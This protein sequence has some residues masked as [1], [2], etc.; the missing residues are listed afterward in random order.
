MPRR[1]RKSPVPYF[2]WLV[3]FRTAQHAIAKAYDETVGKNPP[4]PAFGAVFRIVVNKVILPKFRDLLAKKKGVESMEEIYDMLVDTLDWAVKTPEVR[5]A[6]RVAVAEL[7]VGKVEGLSVDEVAR[8]VYEALPTILEYLR[9]HRDE[10]LAELKAT[11]LVL[12]SKGAA[13]AAA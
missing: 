12:K 13:K 6:I 11:G 1:R 2:E 5:D 10:I 7:G 3:A 8:A 9:A 4:L